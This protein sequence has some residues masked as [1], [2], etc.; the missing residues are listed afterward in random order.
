MGC[1]AS[2]PILRNILSEKELE[3]AAARK[4]NQ[5]QVKKDK[6]LKPA[7]VLS[8]K[9]QGSNASKKPILTDMN[10][11]KL[12]PKENKVIVN[13]PKVSKLE[14]KDQYCTICEDPTG[15]LVYCNGTCLSQF[16][17]S[18]IGLSFI[19]NDFTCDECTSGL[20]PCFD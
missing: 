1:I 16:H 13:L 5:L 14:R 18:C 3:L 8:S 9:V 2:H 6:K 11:N 12:P 7:S 4:A 17:A 20:H 19:P 15:E 10:N